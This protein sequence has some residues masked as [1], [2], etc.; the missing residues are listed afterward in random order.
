MKDVPKNDINQVTPDD[1]NRVSIKEAFGKE[2]NFTDKIAEDFELGEMLLSVLGLDGNDI[3]LTDNLTIN[4]ID[5]KKTSLNRPD[6]IGWINYGTPEQKAVVVIEAQC[7]M[8]DSE[9]SR[10][11]ED[12]AW[13]VTEHRDEYVKDV[14]LV[15]EGASEEKK[16]YIGWKSQG[17]LDIW[18]V[19]PVIIKV[20]D[21]VKTTG[22]EVIQAPQDFEGTTKKKARSTTSET[23]KLAPFFA[24]KRKEYPEYFTS[25]NSG[26][27]SYKKFRKYTV[28]VTGKANDTFVVSIRPTKTKCLP[29]GRRDPNF[30]MRDEPIVSSLK[31]LFG[32]D[33]GE[34]NKKIVYRN[35]NTWE[36]A[37]ELHK[38][39][40]DGAKNGDINLNKAKQ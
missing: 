20:G 39:I 40:V 16:E 29:D 22:F 8:L 10:K 37:F 36:E 13:S 7:G 31:E 15:C 6:N 24:D 19:V 12:Y 1:I 9:H 4:S 14:I 35:F 27:Y 5:P 17:R 32:D 34:G 25:S 11:V 23:E 21:V 26:C 3:T 28:Q 33:W 18:I 2:T 38:N 30:A